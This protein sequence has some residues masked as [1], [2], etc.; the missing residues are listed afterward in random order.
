MTL[1][2]PILIR[3]RRAPNRLLFG[4]HETNL[5]RGRAISDRHVAYYARRAAGGAGVIVTEEASVHESDWPFERAPLARECGPGWRGVVEAVR[6]GGTGT[7]VLAAL[8]HAGGQGSTAYSQRPLWAPSHV[9]EVNSREVPKSMETEDITAVIDGFESAAKRAVASGM[10]GVEVNAGQYSLVRQFLSGLTN[11]RADEWGSDRGAFARSVLEAVRAGLGDDK[12][13]GLRLSCDE[14]APWAGL[15]PQAA[16]DIAVELAPLVDYLVVVRGSIFTTSAT[17]PD[18]HEAPGFNRDLC[19]SIR[20]ALRG[21]GH[22]IPVVLQ[23]SIV[24]PDMADAALDDGT[25]DVVEMTR[26]QIAD[27]ALGRKVAAGRRGE[28][29]PC[30]RCNQLCMVRDARNPIVSCIVD[31][32]SGHELDDPAP[33]G[34]DA[35]PLQG[36][37]ARSVTVIGA[38]PGGLEAARVAALR[39]HQVRVL[40]AA[41][42]PGQRLRFTVAS[43]GNAALGEFADWLV[44]ECE[45]LGVDIATGHEVTPD[46]IARCRQDGDDVIVATGSVDGD[47]P[48][49]VAKGATGQVVAA[50]DLAWHWATGETNGEPR[51]VGEPTLDERAHSIVVL[52]PIGGPIGVAIAE[53][54]ARRPGATVHL[55]TQDHLA[56]NELA[57]T[58][59]LA[60]ANARLQQAGVV[61]ERRTIP[62]R[63]AKA[64]ASGRC[65]VTLEDR[66]TGETRTIVADRIVDAGFRLPD[67]HFDGPAHRIGDAVA[68]RTVH[69][70]ILEARRAVVAIESEPPR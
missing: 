54:L 60:P 13:L 7:L 22:D 17:R 55:V 1:L 52:D 44:R 31:P 56:G 46:E 68:P 5:G 66:F 42:R 12:I 57:R 50:A 70:A 51:F 34:D 32:A 37:S 15:T 35:A 33:V 36:R 28:V 69:E 39:G 40:E 49:R 67:A 8:G 29:R 59:D 10:D 16:A 14:L 47:P 23:G 4:P 58:G 24:D 25:C 26:A 61:I 6:A 27:A 45:R 64:D 11:L 65:K 48:Y 20:A 18:F 38:G 9:P 21:A 62:R 30:V 43:S 19:A 2:D 63:I 3:D 41:E 53:A